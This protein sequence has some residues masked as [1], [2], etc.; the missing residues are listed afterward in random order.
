MDC[1]EIKELFIIGVF[2]KLTILQED[3]IKNH[4]RSCTL[5]EKLYKKKKHLFGL[6]LE[7]PTVPLPDEEDSFRYI[8]KEVFPE[9]KKSVNYPA[10]KKY[11][12]ATI[13]ILII[14]ILGFYAGGYFFSISGKQ[15][16]SNRDVN[17]S[18]MPSIQSY[19]EK[20]LPLLIS[21]VNKYDQ[22][23]E[24]DVLGSEKRIISNILIQTK[25]LKHMVSQ[26][27]NI[28]LLELIEDLEFIL[29]SISNLKAEDSYSN[30]QILKFIKNNNL[31]YKLR[32][33][34][35]NKLVF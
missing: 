3:K 11:V 16:N 33:L 8:I 13:A 14:F 2:G 19:S 25:L 22:K 26:R 15:L 4:I 32:Q 20:I 35:K 30:Y 1:K 31:K 27:R 21:Y 18:N 5:C 23:T 24:K 34:S 6:I 9:S 7:P 28:F 17:I 10:I 12:F 29:M